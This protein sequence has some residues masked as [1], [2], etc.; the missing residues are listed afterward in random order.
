LMREIQ[1]F[2][3]AVFHVKHPD[4]DTQDAQHAWLPIQ[5]QSCKVGHKSSS[6]KAGDLFGRRRYNF[7]L[8]LTH[9]T[10][11]DK[12]SPTPLPSAG[13]LTCFPAAQVLAEQSHSTLLGRFV[14][15]P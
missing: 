12:F 4:H 9:G 15:G 8:I 13:A 1:D 7:Q 5:P 2:C 10:F 11:S 6:P 14:A 3:E